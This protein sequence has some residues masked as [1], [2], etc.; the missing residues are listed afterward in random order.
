[1]VGSDGPM[2]IQVSVGAAVLNS[3][4]FN[5][6]DIPHPAPLTYFEAMAQDLIR[7]ADEALYQAK[8]EGGNRMCRAAAIE[9]PPIRG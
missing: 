1:V 7:Q 9:W 2:P 6:A 3:H 5:P 8:R 4:T